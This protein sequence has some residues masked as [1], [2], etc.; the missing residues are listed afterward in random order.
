MFDSDYLTDLLLLAKVRWAHYKS[1]RVYAFI[2]LPIIRTQV[3][4]GTYI[5]I[6]INNN[7]SPVSSRDEEVVVV[8]V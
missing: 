6:I 1:F 4:N 2:S 7:S 8:V 3:G 5:I